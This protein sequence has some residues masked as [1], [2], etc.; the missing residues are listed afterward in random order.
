MK[1]EHIRRAELRNNTKNQS[2]PLRSSSGSV[3]ARRLAQEARGSIYENRRRRA[4]TLLDDVPG[5]LPDG[6]IF[7]HLH[8]QSRESA[9]LAIHLSNNISNNTVTR[10]HARARS[11]SQTFIE[12][13]MARTVTQLARNSS[14]EHLDAHSCENGILK[15]YSIVPFI[16]SSYRMFSSMVL[17]LL[18]R[19]AF[20]R[21]RMLKSYFNHGAAAL[22]TNK[23][24]PR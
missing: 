5:P 7:N 16:V 21:R 3:L 4:G 9:Q 20:L 15:S 12:H 17:L 1:S 6:T 14:S 18:I 2:T 24:S 8:V 22:D 13:T 19:H 23:H 10:C 11:S